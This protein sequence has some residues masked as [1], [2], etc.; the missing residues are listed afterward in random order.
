MPE[1]RVRRKKNY[2]PPSTAPAPQR[3]GSATWW[4]PVMVT[5]FVLG[6]AWIVLYYIL[7]DVPPWSL[8]GWWNVVVG[9]G[10]IIVGF[11]MSTR[12]R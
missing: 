8:L 10:L 12:W 5:F 7:P 4:A 1:S 3:F 11:A 9:F 6:L 2:T